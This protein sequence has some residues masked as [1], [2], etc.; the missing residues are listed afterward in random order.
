MAMTRLPRVFQF[1]QSV[2]VLDRITR[3]KLREKLPAPPEEIIKPL[4]GY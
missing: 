2:P 3:A 1:L 4:V